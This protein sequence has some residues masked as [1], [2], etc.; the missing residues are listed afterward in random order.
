MRIPEVQALILEL[1]LEIDE[2]RRG[3]DMIADKLRVYEREL[4][5]RKAVRKAVRRRVTPPPD[6]LV[7]LAAANPEDDLMTLGLKAGV[8]PGRISEALRGKRK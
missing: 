1:A 4:C 2:Y 5:R 7:L 3:L 6:Q 8:N